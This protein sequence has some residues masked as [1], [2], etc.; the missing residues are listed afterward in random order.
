MNPHNFDL[1]Q[2][3]QSL[4]PVVVQCIVRHGQQLVG[5]AQSIPGSVVTRVD[6]N[7]VAVRI[8]RHTEAV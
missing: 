1:I 2:K 3:P 5:L 4:S 8:C 7:S 6:G